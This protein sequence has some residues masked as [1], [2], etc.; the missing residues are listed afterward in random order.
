MQRER[1]AEQ[2]GRVLD[3]ADGNARQRA[4][5]I[6]S[7]AVHGVREAASAV[8]RESM[9]VSEG[10]DRALSDAENAINQKRVAIEER[11]RARVGLTL[12]ETEKTFQEI[13]L[14]AAGS[15]SSAAGAVEA[16]RD[17]IGRECQHRLAVAQS[18]VQ[19]SFGSLLSRANVAQRQA[20]T[21][22]E[23]AVQTLVGLGP[24]AT[25]RRGYAIARDAE[26]R[27]V[28]SK[29]AAVKYPVLK[30]Q[31]R[32]GQISVDNRD[33]RGRNGDE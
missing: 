2:T 13:A 27:P 11:A 33:Y 6:R 3:L 9:R 21:L 19:G 12:V 31:F 20:G 15:I 5:E 1:L 10:I 26:D 17:R 25:L 18:D 29:E 24:E 7:G 28:G 32:D 8:E 16:S 22:V 30:V 23:H 4:A 14:T